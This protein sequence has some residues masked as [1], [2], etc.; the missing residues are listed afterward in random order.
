MGFRV[1]VFLRFVL[2]L[3]AGALCAAAQTGPDF[4]NNDT[5][6]Q[7]PE[8]PIRTNPQLPRSL[9][10][11][12]DHWSNQLQQSNPALSPMGYQLQNP[13]VRSH[14]QNLQ[15]LNP[16]QLEPRPTVRAKKPVRS[17]DLNPIRQ[18]PKVL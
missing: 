6:N 3:S 11:T 13:A 17:P 8:E 14:K 10:H 18:E 7:T 9:P 16:E 1:G 5:L 4:N 15:G 12:A 2:L